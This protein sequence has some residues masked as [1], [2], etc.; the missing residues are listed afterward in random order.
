MAVLWLFLAVFLLY[1]AWYVKALTLQFM[2][3]FRLVQKID[4]TGAGC[5]MTVMS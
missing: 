1:G 4:T 3:G 5:E 2:E